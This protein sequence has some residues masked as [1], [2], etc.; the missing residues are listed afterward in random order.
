MNLRFFVHDV[1]TME[2]LGEL[3]P[4]SFAFNDPVWGYGELKMVHTFSRGNTGRLKRLTRPDE[5]AIF[6]K[7][8]Q[9]YLW[10][11]IVDFREYQAPT[12][13][14]QINAHHW[15]SWFYT[16]LMKD[17]LIKTAY[18]KYSMAYDLVDFACAAT[19]KGV[20]KISRMRTLAGQTG[21]YT[22]QPMW[23]IGQALDSFG[24]RD[25][26]FEWSIGFRDNSQTGLPELLFELWAVGAERS[27]R[28]T[29]FLD[30]TKSTNN[31]KIGQWREDATERRSRV[32]ATGDGE[33]PDQLVVPDEDP[34]LKSGRILLRESASN[35]SGVIRA[36]TLF[37]HA[38]AERVARSL[39]QQAIPMSHPVDQPDIKTYR[40]GDRARARIS[41]EWIGDL[42]ISGIRIVDRAVSKEIGSAT[43]ATVLLDFSDIKAVTAK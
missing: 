22:V 9:N 26:G 6:V 8:G 30:Q 40:A 37:D 27:S 33:W 36:E 20:P 24:Q 5:V 4:K 19:E 38:R 7:D 16:R 28:P 2:R 32:F 29:L 25:G 34:E 1:L 10:G 14:V 39:P 43:T 15:K 21:Q 31:V 23:T 12:T 42:D 17:K 3:D 41:D 35:Y 18:D 13:S 11:G